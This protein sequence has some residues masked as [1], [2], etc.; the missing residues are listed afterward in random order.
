MTASISSA[1]AYF[2]DLFAQADPFG[3]LAAMPRSTLPTFATEWLD[4][5][6]NAQDKDIL[7]IWSE[8]VSGFA[9]TEG[10]VLVWGLDCRKKIDGVDAVSDLALIPNPALLV[11]KLPHNIHQST[12]PPVGGIEIRE[13]LQ[14]G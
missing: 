1:K 12:D 10:G 7:K 9:N 2:H 4:F 3:Y 5:K 13:I 14:R 8:A 6:G 11:S